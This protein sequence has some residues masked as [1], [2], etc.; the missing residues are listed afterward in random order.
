L[1]GLDWASIA[2]LPGLVAAGAGLLFGVNA[3]SLD[4]SGSVWRATLPSDPDGLLLA[5][6]VVIAEV[7]LITVGMAVAGAAL[8]AGGRPS[9]TAVAAIAASAAVAV[10]GVVTRCLRWSVTRPHRAE[11]RAAR[12]TPAPP[13]T[14]A[15][16]SA[17]L[18]LRMTLT[19]GLFVVAAQA[20]SV[21]VPVVLAV[22]FLIFSAYSLVGTLRRWRDEHR[23]AAVIVTVAYG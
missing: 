13:G 8:R 17:R 6:A 4:G 14:M 11:L 20:S 3:L 16:Y 5:K 9:A 2:L 18:A 7:A 10:T 12:D 21:S 1:A 15:A 23:R 22:P 19:G